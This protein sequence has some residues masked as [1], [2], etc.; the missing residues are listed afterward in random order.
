MLKRNF[1]RQNNTYDCRI[2][3]I[4]LHKM[5]YLPFPSMPV[6]DIRPRHNHICTVYMS[7]VYNVYIVHRTWDVGDSGHVC[8][9]NKIKCV[10]QRQHN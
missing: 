2:Q 7:D 10:I 4:I 3:Y 9:F 1:W 8:V 5:L 6:S